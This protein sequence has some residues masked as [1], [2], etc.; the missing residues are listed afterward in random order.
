MRLQN[1]VVRAPE[2]VDAA[3][4]AIALSCVAAALT[5]DAAR[6]D[7]VKLLSVKATAAENPAQ[8]HGSHSNHKHTLPLMYLLMFRMLHNKTSH[9]STFSAHL[10]GLGACAGLEFGARLAGDVLKVSRGP[11]VAVTAEALTALQA[12]AINHQGLLCCHWEALKDL[13]LHSLAAEAQAVHAH[14]TG[15]W[16]TFMSSQQRRAACMFNDQRRSWTS[17]DQQLIACIQDN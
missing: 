8:Q 1:G 14:G 13:M 2:E 15:T 3:A 12:L 16:R 10:H 11:S 7:L 5:S 9:C 17:T 4:Q 6:T